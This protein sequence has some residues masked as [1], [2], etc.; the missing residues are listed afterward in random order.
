MSIQKKLKGRKL[1]PMDGGDVDVLTL[2][3]LIV[4]GRPILNF[5]FCPFPNT[6]IKQ[7]PNNL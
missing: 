5:E 3:F 1:R 2:H 7:I 6:F 4:Q